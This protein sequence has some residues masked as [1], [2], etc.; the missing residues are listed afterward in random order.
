MLGKADKVIV[1]KDETIIVDGKWDTDEI[2][3]RANQIRA[4]IWITKSDYD[5]E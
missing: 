2:N 1:N 5:K 4:Q 3:D